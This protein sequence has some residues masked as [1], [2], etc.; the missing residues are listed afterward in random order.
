M[1]YLYLIFLFFSLV[2][3]KAQDNP[4]AMF[5]Y[6]IKNKFEDNQ[7]EW[8]VSN[9][10]TNAIIKE[11]IIKSE[12]KEIWLIGKNGLILNRLT[13]TNTDIIRFISTDP[14]ADF[15]V[16]LSPYSY[17]ANNPINFI[18]YNGEYI[19]INGGKDE[20][21]LYENGKAYN[22]TKDKNGKIVRGKEYNGKNSFISQAISDLNK[23][24]S[25]QKGNNRISDLQ[26]LGVEISIN[27][28]NSILD[29]N[30]NTPKRGTPS[31]IKYSQETG[32]GDGVVFKSFIT[33]AH[34]LQHAWDHQ[35]AQRIEQN[36]IAG[37]YSS[38]EFN[39]IAFENYIRIMFGETKMRTKYDRN[40]VFDESSP[41][42]F[43]NYPR[44]LKSSEVMQV[45]YP[46]NDF[47]NADNT[48]VV[49]SIKAYATD[50]R[51]RAWV[52]TILN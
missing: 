10:D 27:Q 29:V 35:L 48:R 34:E 22:Y 2:L 37:E 36:V 25:T 31:K 23:I 3:V 14:K 8:R 38:S 7:N 45:V 4:Y 41:E 21:V 49:N 52:N 17:T 51:T 18:D 32:T 47:P 26:D 46:R 44:P 42:F 50:S 43:L 5:G 11:I 30:T 19:V 15:Y 24:G 20:S 39:A 9:P 16:G 12:Q 6:E 28:V 13:L 33:L 40:I 1:K